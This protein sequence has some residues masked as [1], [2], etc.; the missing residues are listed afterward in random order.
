MSSNSLQAKAILQMIAD[1]DRGGEPRQMGLFRC[2]DDIL[3]EFD[4]NSSI[5]DSVIDNLLQE[6]LIRE[7]SEKFEKLNKRP[8]G[9][10]AYQL[11]EMGKAIMQP[12]ATNNT[13]ISNNNGSNI[14]LN[15]PNTNQNISL[16]SI[17]PS[18]VQKINEFEEAIR[19]KDSSTM[20]KVFAYIADKSVDIAIALVTGSIAR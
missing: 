4:D 16:S 7:V 5:V 2:Y 6:G 10:K 14:A 3:Q 18:L 9:Y 1:A 13:I 15:S 19:N 17:D 20:K 8:L 11:T 12:T